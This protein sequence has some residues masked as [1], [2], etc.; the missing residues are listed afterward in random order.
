MTPRGGT[1]KLFSHRRAQFLHGEERA[2]LWGVVKM[3]RTLLLGSV[4]ALLAFTLAAPPPVMAERGPTGTVRAVVRYET[5][6]GSHPLVGVEVW[7]GSPDGSTNMYVCT[8]AQGIAIISDVAANTDLLSAT[9]VSVSPLRETCVT[10]PEF[11]NPDTGKQMTGVSWRNHHG[12]GTFNPFVVGDGETFTVRY[13]AKT[14]QQQGRICGGSW[15]TWLG[16]SGIDRYTGT[17]RNDVI[18]AGGGA[19]VINSA[20]GDFDWVCGGTGDDTLRGSRGI[21]FI[22]GGPG[23][24]VLIGGPGD[25]VL[26]GGPGLDTCVGGA[27]YDCE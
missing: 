5:K 20:G 21:D 6:T 3:R 17:S 22:V 10:N 27:E 2:R 13:V 7:V 24:D 14:P 19:D 4:G 25:N 18:Q 15:A 9:G 11:L 26:I 16:T 8:D 1:L 12:T 23:D